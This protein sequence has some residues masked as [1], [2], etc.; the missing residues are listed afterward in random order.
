MKH[1]EIIIEPAH[2]TTLPDILALLTANQLPPEG[3]SD[4]IE[5]ALVARN[6]TAIIGSAALE[7]YG[8]AALLRSV[9]VDPNFQGQGLGQQL[10]QAAI[11]L[12]QQHNIRHLYLLTETAANFFPKFGFYNIDRAQVP[13]EVKTSLEFTTLCPDSARVMTLPV[14]SQ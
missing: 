14:P 7:M 11:A 9:A 4:H 13:S 12:A 10:T 3:L 2:E 5:T 1:P 8:S 6:G